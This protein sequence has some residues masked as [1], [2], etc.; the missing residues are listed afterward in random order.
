MDTTQA[1]TFKIL[2]KTSMHTIYNLQREQPV[3]RFKAKTLISLSTNETTK[4][5]IF[6][7]DNKNVLPLKTT[8]TTS[9]SWQDQQI[10]VLSA[11]KTFAI[12]FVQNKVTKLYLLNNNTK[13]RRRTQSTLSPTEC[14]SFGKFDPFRIFHPSLILYT[15]T[16]PKTLYLPCWSIS[17]IS[18]L[19]TWI[20]CRGR[21]LWEP[22]IQSSTRMIDSL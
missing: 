6:P 20:R 4:T 17:Y 3:H 2:S 8:H 18:S 22:K 13:T 16:I 5:T 1:T 11:A 10:Y 15:L 14:R 19:T 7:I 21:V 9:F 12:F